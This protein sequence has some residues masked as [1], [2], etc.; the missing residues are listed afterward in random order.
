MLFRSTAG[1]MILP[2][3]GNGTVTPLYSP[4]FCSLTPG[5]L[6]TIDGNVPTAPTQTPLSGFAFNN[7]FAYVAGFG[8][9]GGIGI[10]T[11]EASTGVLDNCTT[12]PSLTGYYG[13]MAVH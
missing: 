10:C 11:F 7:G 4:T 6:C 13:G 8:G 12:S 9:G 2:I 1:D 5:T 3:A